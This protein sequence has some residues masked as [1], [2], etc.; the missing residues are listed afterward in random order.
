MGV[1]LLFGAARSEQEPYR[2]EVIEAEDDGSSIAG[3]AEG[4]R[5]AI[6][7]E[8]VRHLGGPCAPNPRVLDA[9]ERDLGR[10]GCDAPGRVTRA[11]PNFRDAVAH[12]Q[13]APRRREAGTGA[14]HS[15]GDDVPARSDIRED[16]G[17]ARV[18]PLAGHPRED[19][20]LRDHGD[21]RLAGKKRVVDGPGLMDVVAFPGRPGP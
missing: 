18:D 10:R 19:G 6:D 15:F 16:L 17:I 2:H 5:I 8:C 7:H 9:V 14:R 12:R 21:P 20:G 13:S 11:P 1:G 3:S 4:P